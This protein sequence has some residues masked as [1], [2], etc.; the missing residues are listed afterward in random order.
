MRLA[1]DTN[2]LVYAEGLNDAARKAQ[3]RDLL[4]RLARADVVLPV[5]VAGELFR[6]LVRKARCTPAEAR[7]AVENWQEL[8][9]SEPTTSSAFASAMALSSGHAMDI[10]DT[11]IVAVAAEAGCHLLLSEDLAEGFAWR[12]VTVTNPF[13]AKPHP[14][15]RELLGG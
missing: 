5:Q 2:I 8:F 14:L 13:A 9:N 10:W 15:L 7:I 6:V 11:T 1:L 12:G 4:S 3:A